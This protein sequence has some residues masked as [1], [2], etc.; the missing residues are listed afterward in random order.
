VVESV[1]DLPALVEGESE[2]ASCPGVGGRLLDRLE[3]GEVERADEVG[4]VFEPGGRLD[5]RVRAVDPPGASVLFDV[6]DRRDLDPCTTELDE[7]L[8]SRCDLVTP[9]AAKVDG[10]RD[11][12]RDGAADERAK[13]GRPDLAQLGAPWRSCW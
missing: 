7:D 4:P 2:F 11:G 5:L 9:V 6:D 8:A 10:E 3:V 12:E 1:A 13:E